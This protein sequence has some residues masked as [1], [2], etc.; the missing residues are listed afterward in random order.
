MGSRVE[1]EPLERGVSGTEHTIRKMHRLV[2][3][4][5]L[6]PTIQKI[7][8]WIRLR[9]PKD[10]RGTTRQT[11]DAVFRWVR[12][13]GV[14]Q[15]DPFQIEKI[16]HPIESMRPIVEARRAG[17][18]RGPG[19]F[20]GDCDTMAGVYLA[21]L[22]GA[23][24]FH[25]AFETAKTDPS[26]PDE[27]SH[28]WVAVRIGGEWY[29]LDPSTPGAEPGWRPPVPPERFRRWVEEPVEKTMGLGESDGDEEQPPVKQYIPSDYFYGIPGGRNGKASVP[30]VDP[31]SMVRLTPEAVRPEDLE[32][33]RESLLTRGENSADAS[34]LRYEDIP[35]SRPYYVPQYRGPRVRPMKPLAHGSVWNRGVHVFRDRKAPKTRVSVER[36]DDEAMPKNVEVVMGDSVVVEEPRRVEVG[37]GQASG[38]QAKEAAKSV[39]ERMASTIADVAGAL[40]I[41]KARQIEAKYANRLVSA[42]NRVAGSN[43]I[44]AA[45]LISRPVSTPG[46]PAWVLIGGGI[47]TAGV[48]YVMLRPSKGRRRR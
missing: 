1:V 13:H 36:L 31:G 19:L 24:G 9:V 8:T 42:T 23:L 46:I 40:G 29:P 5:K 44:G 25:Y 33:D 47:A 41:A 20:V 17:A 39:W 2:A 15:R 38:E 37:V 4:G 21:S 11:A 26:R 7:A 22:L 32:G 10:Y 30:E 12:R 28:V 43:V 14:F 48:A 3:L 16:E 34:E 18:Y 27:F 45:D 35:Q 6:D